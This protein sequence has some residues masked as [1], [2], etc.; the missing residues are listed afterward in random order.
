MKITG[1]ITTIKE[2]E[3][4][5]TKA[6]KGWSKVTFLVETTE[7]YNN[8]YCFNIFSMDDA[9]K[10]NVENFTKFNTLN[11]DVDVD[12]NVKTTEW[13]GK[14][15]TELSAWKVFKADAK[16][17]ETKEDEDDSGNLPF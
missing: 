8:L 11:Q 13:N 14:Y 4:G 12:F 2:V 7:D 15:F 5:T 10:N 9:E 16:A 3:K 6:G 1:K 17:E